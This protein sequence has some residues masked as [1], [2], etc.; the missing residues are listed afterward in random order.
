[1]LLFDLGPSARS[2]LQLL[3]RL[4]QQNPHVLIIILASDDD[5]ALLF[6]GL[7]F[8]VQGYL[9]RSTPPAQILDAI[10]EV[11]EGGAPMSP[12]IARQVIQRFRA[13]P[14]WLAQLAQLTARERETLDHL[15]L[16]CSC[17][18]IADRL[19]VS[20]DTVRTHLRSIYQKLGV[21]SCTEALAS[22]L[23]GSHARVNA[24]SGA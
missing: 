23:R 12:S 10:R 3:C 21:H 6:R 13:P 18:S 5:A 7:E 8:G 14:V 9:L 15:S 2:G 16:G 1:V 4:R 11:I 19:G 24:L 22:Y 17:K 20:L